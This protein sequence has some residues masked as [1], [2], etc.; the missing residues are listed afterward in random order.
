MSCSNKM[1]GTM[2]KY[3]P[4]HD[5][6]QKSLYEKISRTIT[7][8]IDKYEP[9]QDVA[10]LFQSLQ[11]ITIATCAVEFSA[12]IAFFDS[13]SALLSSSSVHILSTLVTDS[14]TMGI[15]ASTTFL[16]MIVGI[17]AYPRKINKTVVDYRQATAERFEEAIS[18]KL[19]DISKGELIKLNQKIAEGI[20]PYKI[21]CMAES[22]R[23]QRLQTESEEI[24]AIGHNLRRRIEKKH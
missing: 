14:L 18:S 1:V 24:L 17:I 20:L 2:S 5:Q 8:E 9:E 19:L 13:I 4:T 21:F 16:T 15:M 11:R 7:Q 22:D 3:T 12:A 10:Q 6:I 23:I